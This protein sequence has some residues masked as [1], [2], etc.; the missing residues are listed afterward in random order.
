MSRFL[1]R[2]MFVGWLTLLGVSTFLVE[3]KMLSDGSPRIFIPGDVML[4]GLAPI[5]YPPG[6][7]EEDPEQNSHGKFSRHCR[8]PFNFRGLQHA[9]AIL[10]ALDQINKNETLLPGISLGVDIKDTC[11]SV[12]HTIQE[13]LQFGFIRAAYMRAELDNIRACG[14]TLNASTLKTLPEMGVA[15]VG[16]AYSGI[17]I[18]VANLVGLFHVPVVS[19]AS[20]SRLLSDRKR[21]KNFLRTVPSDTCQAQAMVDIIREL[22]WNFVSTVASDTEYGRSGIDAFKQLIGSSRNYSRICIA[23]DEVFTVRTPKAKVREIMLKIRKHPEAKVIVLFAE[24]NDAD[25]FIIVAREENMAG[26]IWI[27]SDAFARSYSVFRNNKDILKYWINIEPNSKVFE[28]FR[29]YFENITQE[30]L[31]RNPWLTA[32]RRYVKKLL[33][34]TEPVDY[35]SYTTTAIDAVY[36][37]AYGLHN[38]YRCSDKACLVHISNTIQSEVYNFIKNSS[39]ASPSGHRVSFDDSGSAKAYYN[40]IFLNNSG[41]KYFFDILGSWYL[42]E[43]FKFS[44]RYELQRHPFSDFQSF[45]RCSPRCRPGHWKDPK[46]HY[47]E[48]CWSCLRCDGNSISNQSEATACVSCPEGMTANSGKSYCIVI[49]SKEIFHTIPGMAVACVSGVGISAVLVTFVSIFKQRNTP[50]VKASSRGISY[51][52]LFGLAWCYA[53]P[54]AFILQPTSLFCQIHPFL[55]STGVALVIG[56]LLTKTNRIARIFST[57]TMRTGKAY[58]L[59]NKWQLLFVLLCVLVENCIAATWIIVSPQKPVRVTYGS[60]QV[61][62]ECIGESLEGVTIWAVFNA[63]LI[64]LCTYQAFLVRKVPANYNEAKFIT[65][66][67]VTVCISGAVFIPTALGTKGLYRTI[68]ACFL[69]ILCCTVALVCLFGPKLYVILYRPEKN[70][71]HEPKTELKPTGVLRPQYCR[72]ISSLSTLTITNS[73]ESLDNS[74]PTSYHHTGAL[75]SRLQ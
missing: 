41:G 11:N 1:S 13:S 25:Y 33:N 48:C 17:T 56:A 46:K 70:L 42:G 4:A 35:S 14:L 55:I 47:P 16:A 67:M 63:A 27:G 34:S 58:F 72:S 18:A 66:S 73:L 5:H 8:G 57:K 44:S 51:V 69:F 23:V 74:Q 38:M 54:I 22:D 7:R 50:I 21:F 19:Y 61:V 49:P 3:M 6:T 43:R 52:L 15:L 64:L 10:Y 75:A 20:T 12:D 62:L 65:F 53:L 60:H 37:V 32:Y 24:M 30:R 45:A 40:I 36:A 71:P 29:D 28:P 26:Y 31:K 39:F 68:T 2:N 9:E 59:S